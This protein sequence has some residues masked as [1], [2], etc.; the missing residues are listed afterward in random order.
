MIAQPKNRMEVYGNWAVKIVAVILS[1]ALIT[2]YN[3]SQKQQ[4]KVEA[5]EQ[6]K[7]DKVEFDKYC[8]KEDASKIRQE[9]M[10]KKMMESM[11][12]LKLDVREVK[13]E[14]KIRNGRREG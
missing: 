10:Y 1:F 7:L 9:D 13:T 12:E 8:D 11:E 4:N 6:R 3:G 14:L 5:L 2:A